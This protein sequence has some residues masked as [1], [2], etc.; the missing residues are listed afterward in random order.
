MRRTS[1]S[2][3]NPLRSSASTSSSRL[4]LRLDRVEQLA[5]EERVPS[6]HVVARACLGGVGIVPHSPADELA[7]GV[8]SEGSEH[9]PL[10]VGMDDRC[11]IGRGSG[12][13]DDEHRE[14][15]DPDEQVP[16]PFTRRFVEPLRIVDDQQQ[17]SGGGQVGE[18][19]VQAVQH[20]EAAGGV[21]GRGGG[22]DRACEAGCAP[23]QAI[24]ISRPQ[25][26]DRWF[27]Q[28]TDDTEPECG[29]ELGPA[30]RQHGTPERVGGIGDR[31]EERGLA[32][33]GT[34]FHQHRAAVALRREAKVA[35]DVGE[36]IGALEERRYD[37]ARELVCHGRRPYGFGSAPID[38]RNGN[39]WDLR[40]RNFGPRWP[41]AARPRVRTVPDMVPTSRPVR[42]PLSSLAAYAVVAV[43]LTVAAAATGA[44]VAASP[45]GAKA[46]G[47]ATCSQL[48]AKELQPL[49]ADP[50][51]KIS[52]QPIA[53]A[54]YFQ[55]AK[56]VGETC[57]VTSSETSNALTVTV[58]GGPA[59]ANAW[60]SE[61]HSIDGTV[62]L[63][64]VGTK[65]VRAK[66]D[67][68]GAVGTPEVVALK[69]ST[70]CAVDPGDVDNVPGAGALE[71]A[72]GA[73]SDIGDQAYAIIAAADGTV[74][75][76]IFGSGN[77]TPDLS[78]LSS[79][80]VTT[81]STTELGAG[82]LDV[83]K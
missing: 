2:D 19:P 13:E 7:H 75:N 70:Y 58:I 41:M 8:D 69:G 71:E 38:R 64:G 55:K 66:V 20:R 23:E 26:T 29:L 79:I 72:A 62:S 22:D 57:T 61:L 34:A 63:P 18:Q 25:G 16:Q 59:A 77:T 43:T 35:L 49:V 80:T 9:D 24:A 3:A 44:V 31:T 53:G 74:C 83:Q 42:R 73:T 45:A 30:G 37:D 15:V 5:D 32:D 82:G 76:R 54:Q 47:G 11:G 14:L 56:K 12:G 78:K 28:L 81:P 27:E 68:D 65:A 1:D 51:S 40:L 39:C 48:T 67:A 21:A 52:S 50:I 60:K 17:G 36:G 4:A 6:G 10:G 46:S 33:A